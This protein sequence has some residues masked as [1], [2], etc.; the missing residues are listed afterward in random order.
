MGV[1]VTPALAEARSP[2]GS[3][4]LGDKEFIKAFVATRQVQQYPRR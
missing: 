1:K 4:L 2:P 3:F